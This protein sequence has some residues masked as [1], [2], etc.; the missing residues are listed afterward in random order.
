MAQFLQFL[1]SGVTVGT[2]Y[3]L[4]ALGFALIYNASHVINFAQGEFVMLGG[5]TTISLYATG[6]PLPLAALLAILA[7]A[8]VGVA[9]EKV[10]VEPAKAASVESI[11]IITIGASIFLRGGA[12]IIW[13]KDFHRLPAFSGEEPINVLGAALQPQ[14]LWVIGVATVIVLGLRW[15]FE[16]TLLGKAMLAVAANRLAAQLCGVSVRR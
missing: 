4:V 11:I 12:Q 5:M 14:S 7:T 6:V 13:G 15:F 10:A 3:A 1:F 2:I 9:L 16:S 8:L